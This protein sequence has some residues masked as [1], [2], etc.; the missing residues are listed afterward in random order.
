L[1]SDGRLGQNGGIAWGKVQRISGVAQLAMRMGEEGR[2]RA[3]TLFDEEE[4]V[5]RQL[6]IYEHICTEL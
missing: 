1:E 5:G 2:R 3:A 6:A 4:V